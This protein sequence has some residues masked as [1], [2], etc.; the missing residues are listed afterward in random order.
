[1]PLKKSG[2]DARDNANLLKFADGNGSPQAGT[3]EL[4][5]EI[6][7]LAVL[8][9]EVRKQTDRIEAAADAIGDAI[10]HRLDSA[11]I[12]SPW[13]SRT[14]KRTTSGQP[15]TSARLRALLP[16]ISEITDVRS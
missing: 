11:R 15:K 4:L 3:E 12:T 2:V 16:R 9:H 7:N 13:T 10:L 6:D 14:S 1:M 8:L 5:D